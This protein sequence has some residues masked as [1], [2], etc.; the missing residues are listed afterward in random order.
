MVNA[1]GTDFDNDCLAPSEMSP[2]VKG[3]L[4]SIGIIFCICCFCVIFSY[5]KISLLLCGKSRAGADASCCLHCCMGRESDGSKGYGSGGSGGLAEWGR[6]EDPWHVESEERRRTRAFIASSAAAGGGGGV[7][8]NDDSSHVIYDSDMYNVIG[9]NSGGY[10]I[11]GGGEI[12]GRSYVHLDDDGG[13]I[14]SMH[15]IHNTYIQTN[16]HNPDPDVTI[17]LATAILIPISGVNGSGS[18]SSRMIYETSTYNPVAA[19]TTTTKTE[20]S[21][22]PSSSYSSQYS[23]T[24]ATTIEQSEARRGLEPESPPPPYPYHMDN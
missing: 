15:T 20:P 3:I 17:P 4:I 8:S 18:N 14:H 6:N 11:G 23:M 1:C 5:H 24:M 12:T 2:I 22:P 7:V 10:S 21:A 13:S 19:A 9:G 16:P